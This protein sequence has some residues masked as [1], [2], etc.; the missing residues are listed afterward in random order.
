MK[1]TTVLLV[2]L[3]LIVI[4]VAASTARAQDAPQ[5]T[6]TPEDPAAQAAALL[7]EINSV[8]PLDKLP[9]YILLVAQRTVP[10]AQFSGFQWDLSDNLRPLYELQGLQDNKQLEIGIF[11]DGSINRINRT[12]TMSDVPVDV[13]GMLDKYVRD[14]EVSNVTEATLASG[15]HRFEFAGRSGGITLAVEIADSANQIRI[16]ELQ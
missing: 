14:F 11:M 13:I 12:I 7:E 6:A 1:R 8:Q 15:V 5:P 16:V 4:G 2:L 10:G 9:P 3:M